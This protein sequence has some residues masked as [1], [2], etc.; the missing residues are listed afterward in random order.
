MW[1]PWLALHSLTVHKKVQGIAFVIRVFPSTS[2]HASVI[3]CLRKSVVCIPRLY[4]HPV[5]RSGHTRKHVEIFCGK[6]KSD[7]QQ[8][9]KSRRSFLMLISVDSESPFSSLQI[10]AHQKWSNSGLY[11]FQYTSASSLIIPSSCLP[12]PPQY[13]FFVVVK[14]YRSPTFTKY[15]LMFAGCLWG[16]AMYTRSGQSSLMSVRIAMTGS[17]L[18]SLCQCYVLPRYCKQTVVRLTI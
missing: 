2:L 14:L 4:V 6:W 11:F 13:S 3:C 17:R 10:S 16:V 7:R 9:N 8:F 5:M 18:S 12:H 1:S 15:L